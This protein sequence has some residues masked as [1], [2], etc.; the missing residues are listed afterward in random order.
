[1]RFPRVSDFENRVDEAGNKVCRN[2]ENLV[3]KGRRHYCSRECMHE[4][5]QNHDWFWVRKAVLRRD[6]YKCGICLK[7]HKKA[8]L[9]VD[10]I[11]PVRKGIDPFDK[12]NLRLLCRECHKAKTRLDKEANF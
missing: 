7:R 9:D 1:M 6:N 11:I 5:N 10:H 4:F 8:N 2:C 12:A 3:A